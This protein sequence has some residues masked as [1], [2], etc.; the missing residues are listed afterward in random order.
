MV[1]PHGT[2]C[3]SECSIIFREF[4]DKMKAAGP[5]K[6]TAGK[7]VVFLLLLGILV[8]I[9]IH[10]AAYFGKVE[11]ARKFDLIGSFLG[12]YKSKR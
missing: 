2:F 10:F 12:H 7:Q 5:R 6:S 4:R 1:T 11:V 9:G 3:S 8:I